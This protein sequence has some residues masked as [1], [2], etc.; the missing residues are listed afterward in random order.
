MKF[1]LKI[2]LDNDGMK[3][4]TDISEAL[5]DIASKINERPYLPIIDGHN[6]SIRDVN[7]NRIGEWKFD[8]EE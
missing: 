5:K 2:E 8:E 4:R 7:G 1:I 3:S 6:S